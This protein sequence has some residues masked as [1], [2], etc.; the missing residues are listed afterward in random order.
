M[1]LEK[2]LDCITPENK[3]LITEKMVSLRK[4]RDHLRVELENTAALDAQAVASTKM[5]GRLV[6]PANQFRELWSVATLAEKK[7]FFSFMIETIS[8]QPK[9]KIAEIRLSGKY[10]ELKR[11]SDPENGESFLYACRGEWI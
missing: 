10:L 1:H 7:E 4:E 8:I 6:E 5:V 2:L 9:R 11:I 3:D